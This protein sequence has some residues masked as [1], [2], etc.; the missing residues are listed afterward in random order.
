MN[1]GLFYQFMFHKQI[2]KQEKEKG[3]GQGHAQGV[4]IPPGQDAS[5]RGRLGRFDTSVGPRD[6]FAI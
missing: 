2:Q 5:E 4:E 3:Q 1:V 6:G